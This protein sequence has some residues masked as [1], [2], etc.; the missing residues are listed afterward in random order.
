MAVIATCAAIAA[1][2][3]PAAAQQARDYWFLATSS[4][5]TAAEYIDVG[6]I[7]SNADVKRGWTWYFYA[8]NAPK[9]A[10]SNVREIDE[11]NCSTRQFRGLQVI[12][13]DRQGNV[14]ESS[15]A[16]SAWAYVVPDTFGETELN[17]VCSSAATRTAIGTHLGEGV[18]PQ[19]DAEQFFSGGWNVVSQTP[20]SGPEP[21]ARSDSTTVPGSTGRDLSQ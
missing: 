13:Y 4:D 7:V 3:L 2:S 1:G 5:K 18:T 14:L 6:S 17:F 21:A 12:R 16:T 19:Y 9:F 11:W 15:N 10:G 20:L 8:N